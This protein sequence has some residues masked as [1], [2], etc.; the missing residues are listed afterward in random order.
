MRQLVQKDG[1]YLFEQANVQRNTTR[2]NGQS[3]V[4]SGMKNYI[5]RIFLSVLLVAFGFSCDKNYNHIIPNVPVSFTVNLNIINELTVPGNSVFYP[6]AGFGG[7]VIYCELPG[8]YFAFDAACT[9]EISRTCV[10]ENEGVLATCP[11]CDS[12]FILL[13]GAYPS[14]GPATLPL[15]QYNV[16]TV[17]DF[18]LRIYN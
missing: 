1:K 7:V 14:R 12:Q 18:T 11:C 13:S 3:T 2:R 17:N 4:F 6:N 10:V 9:N 15:K 16:S 8:S 5:V